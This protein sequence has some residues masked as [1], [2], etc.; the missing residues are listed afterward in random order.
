MSSQPPDSYVISRRIGDAT[1][2]VISE[3]ILSW[4][5]ELQ[6]PEPEWRRAMPEADELGLVP[7]G[8]NVVHVRLGSASVI[9]D[10]GL[11]DPDTEWQRRYAQE[12]PGLTRTPGLEAGLVTAG[13]APDEVTHVL[14]THTHTD[15]Y[16]GVTRERTGNSP[17]FPNARY[18]LGRADWDGNPER[19]RP[20]SD[21]AT[22]LGEIERLGLLA[23]LDSEQE[24]LPGLTAIP[25][26]G[27][28]PGHTVYRFR[29]AGETFFYVGDLFHHP[30][31]VEHL[32]WV[33]RG[34]HQPGVQSSRERIYAEA[35]SA[36][37]VVVSTHEPFPPFGRIRR[38]STGYVW[39][40]L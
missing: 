22:R 32:T 4:P 23:P 9:I 37:A 26:P 38:T 35:A 3:G 40:R 8:L 11:D 28:S 13:I 18:V 12:A 29:S 17:R 1:V 6:V 20:G 34:R 36:N 24:I 33:S 25:S 39:R 2:T 31:E 19:D 10:P 5:L 15:H 14:I 16:C 27:E 21:I 30:C 7:L